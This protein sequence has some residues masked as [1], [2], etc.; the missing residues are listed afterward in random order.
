MKFGLRNKRGGGGKKERKQIEKGVRERAQQR[1]KK[2]HIMET[3]RLLVAGGIPDAPL[4]RAL[5]FILPATWL[6]TAVFLSAAP[7]FLSMITFAPS[8]L[9]LTHTYPW[10]PLISPFV[11]LRFVSMLCSVAVV[12]LWMPRL[13]A[14]VGTLPLA[15]FLA[16]VVCGVGSLQL[17]ILGAVAVGVAHVFWLYETYAGF[18]PCAMAILVAWSQVTCGVECAFSQT[19]LP[20]LRT[21]HLPL[22]LLLI[23]ACADWLPVSLVERN[24]AEEADIGGGDEIFDGPMLLPCALSFY[25]AW[26]VLRFFWV[27]WSNLGSNSSVGTTQANSTLANSSSKRHGEAHPSFSLAYFFFPSPLQKLVGWV[28]SLC[29]PLFRRFGFG[30]DVAAAALAHS[31]QGSQDGGP[32][33]VAPLQRAVAAVQVLSTSDDQQRAM[34]FLAPLPGSTTADADRRRAVAL[35]ALTARLQQVT[36][37]NANQAIDVEL[38]FS[39]EE[40]ESHQEELNV[41]GGTA[42]AVAKQKAT[43]D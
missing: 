31:Q 37:R 10:I 4:S 23:V 11:E 39:L 36:E 8:D 42:V 43:S 24:R 15:R 26:C 33:E 6:V 5:M 22:S 17:L 34:R 13:E 16:L 7:L 28:S 21:R 30:A 18:L 25:T 3:V 14:Q 19:V 40:G 32:V 27:P 1:Q 38:D 35:A 12:A 20:S 29:F 9:I 2:I 41:R